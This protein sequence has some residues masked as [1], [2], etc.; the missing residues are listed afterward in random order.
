VARSRKSGPGLAWLLLF[1]PAIFYAQKGDGVRI[2]AIQ[3]SGFAPDGLP[4]AATASGPAAVRA[5]HFVF[6]ALPGERRLTAYAAPA[7]VL[8]YQP[9]RK[10]RSNYPAPLPLRI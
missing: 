6:A 1:L 4:S 3:V 7:R 5:G 10:S 2:Q 8:S 9:V